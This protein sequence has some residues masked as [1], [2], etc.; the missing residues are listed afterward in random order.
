M[1][2]DPSFKIFL[3]WVDQNQYQ[4]LPLPVVPIGHP[5]VAV[6]HL[7]RQHHARLTT[8]HFSAA[9]ATG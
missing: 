9:A 3:L 4:L 7:F 8:V 6:D 2:V 1:Y 5:A